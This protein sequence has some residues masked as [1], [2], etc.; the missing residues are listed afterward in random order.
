MLPGSIPGD[1]QKHRGSALTQEE[2][3]SNTLPDP[4]VEGGSF[5]KTDKE[6]TFSLTARSKLRSVN[7]IVV[8][9]IEKSYESFLLVYLIDQDKRT[10]YVNAPLVLQRFS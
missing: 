10:P 3:I 8:I 4:F 2:R 1:L 5:I 9:E 6:I 7:V